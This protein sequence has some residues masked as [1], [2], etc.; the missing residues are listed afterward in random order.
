MN[1]CNCILIWKGIYLIHTA[2][3]IKTAFMLYSLFIC[4]ENLL[5]IQ[6]PKLWAT[7]CWAPHR[8]IFRLS[9][10]NDVGNVAVNTINYTSDISSPVTA[11]PQYLWRQPCKDTTK[12]YLYVI[13]IFKKYCSVQFQQFTV[14]I[15]CC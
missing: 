7:L 1:F 3:L 12:I 13:V 9:R 10:I 14:I 6:R 11:R 4:C 2:W 15:F 5:L 8:K